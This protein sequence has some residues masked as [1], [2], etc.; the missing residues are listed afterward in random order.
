[1]QVFFSWWEG[2]GRVKGKINKLKWNMIRGVKVG[3]TEME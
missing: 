1:M 3:R 2:N